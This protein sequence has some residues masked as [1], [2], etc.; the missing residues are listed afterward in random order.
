MSSAAR[1]VLLGLVIALFV[2]YLAFQLQG[3]I[4]GSDLVLFTP[5]NGEH[6]KT[7]HIIIQGRA[8]GMSFLFLDGRQVFSDDNGY[9]EEELILPYGLNIIRMTGKGRFGRTFEEER[10]IYVT[11]E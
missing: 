3:F 11:G 6:V 1:N 8:T 9:F 7:S 5:R 2:G 4:F 10:M